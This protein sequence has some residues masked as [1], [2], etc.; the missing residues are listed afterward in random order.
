MTIKT[1]DSCLFE[2]FFLKF[3]NVDGVCSSLPLL[4]SRFY[5]LVKHL[6]APTRQQIP[7]ASTLALI[8]LVLHSTET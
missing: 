7:E 2:A 1:L 5:I 3:R 6:F 4:L 8:P